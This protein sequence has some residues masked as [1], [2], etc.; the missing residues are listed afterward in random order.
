MATK[1]K[2]KKHRHIIMTALASVVLGGFL[3]ASNVQKDSSIGG[4]GAHADLIVSRILV[5]RTAEILGYGEKYWVA[6]VIKNVGTTPVSRPFSITVKAPGYE[7]GDVQRT[8]R[9]FQPNA[10]VWDFGWIEG[11]KVLMPGEEIGGAW[12][13]PVY[14]KELGTYKVSAVVDS[15][16]EIRESDE[17]N[18][19]L[20]KNFE[21]YMAG[22]GVPNVRSVD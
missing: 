15:S 2:V 19:E 22:G 7:S 1:T 20:T 17:N 13:Y 6:I 21:I 10:P 3:L 9:K 4:S 8:N 11:G 12:L 5:L 18:N 16:S 14:L